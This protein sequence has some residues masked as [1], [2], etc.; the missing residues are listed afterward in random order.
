MKLSS[1]IRSYQLIAAHTNSMKYMK[2][3]AS[4]TRPH[5]RPVSDFLWWRYWEIHYIDGAPVATST[6][7]AVLQCYDFMAEHVSSGSA[8]GGKNGGDSWTTHDERGG[9][10]QT[11]LP[12]HALVV[13]AP[14][15]QLIISGAKKWEV[16]TRNTHLRGRV[17]IA[18][19]GS[20][21]LLGEVTIVGSV[22]MTIS[23]IENYEMHR[24]KNL[25][26]VPQ[27]DFWAWVLQHPCPYPVPIPYN[28]PSG[29]ISWVRLDKTNLSD[30]TGFTS[31]GCFFFR[32]NH[33]ISFSPSPTTRI[34][35]LVSD[36]VLD[37]SAHVPSI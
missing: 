30:F 21:T 11:H 33:I 3:F 25:E 27:N 15:A 5:L 31:V 4:L 34:L 13:K 17:S 20:Q 35:N 10:I 6:S 23:M 19:S 8:S 22:R 9:N 37:Q 2:W 28:H 7:G 18:L 26:A 24:I 36:S 29:A 14:F 16:R 1:N 32:Q 12:D